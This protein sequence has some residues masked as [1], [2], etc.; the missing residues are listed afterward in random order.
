MMFLKVIAINKKK[1][2]R[3]RIILVFTSYDRPTGMFENSK[4][5]CQKVYLVKL[6]AIQPTA[7]EHELGLQLGEQSVPKYSYNKL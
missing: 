4:Y 6:Y 2:K 1:I 7:H 3:G 5:I